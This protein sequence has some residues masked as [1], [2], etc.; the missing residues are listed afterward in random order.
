MEAPKT[1]EP[2]V[3][4]SRLV[5]GSIAFSPKYVC[6]QYDRYWL[7]STEIHLPLSHSESLNVTEIDQVSRTFY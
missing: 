7:N 2:N 1:W 6:A 3:K 5:L 4:P